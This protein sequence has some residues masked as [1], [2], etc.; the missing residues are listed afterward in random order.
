MAIEIRIESTWDTDDGDGRRIEVTVSER[1]H[2]SEDPLEDTRYF[3][4][5]DFERLKRYLSDLFERKRSSFMDPARRECDRCGRVLASEDRAKQFTCPDCSDLA[6]SA[7][8]L[9]E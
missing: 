1:N 2:P 7:G 8:A 6:G 9:L 3:A 4:S 5:G